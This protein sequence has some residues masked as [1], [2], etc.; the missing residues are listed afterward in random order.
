MFI[1]ASLVLILTPGPDMI[2]VI[3]RAIGQGRMA[4]ILSACGVCGGLIIHTLAAALGLALLLKSC[5]SA[6]FIIKY[7]GAAYLIYLGIK[8]L[9]GRQELKTV[10]NEQ[11]QSF[12]NLFLQGF[13][14]NVLNPKVA[15]FFV[16]FL[17]QF[18]NEQSS[19]AAVQS[20]ILGLI[21]FLLCL[22]VLTAVAVLAGRI[23]KL[24]AGKTS[25][26]GKISWASGSVLIALGI[27]LALPDKN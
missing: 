26:G 25:V 10:T 19:L 7:L 4:G 1:G 23:G 27:N 5:S 6:Y 2:Y 18:V 9:T 20:V 15:L 22:G 13:L 17:P 16:S 21:Y 8:S 11:R 14:T 12:E 24:M 3:T